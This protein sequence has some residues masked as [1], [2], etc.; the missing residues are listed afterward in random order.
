MMVAQFVIFKGKFT[1]LQL[2]KAIGLPTP[3]DFHPDF[4][5]TLDS[6]LVLIRWDFMHKIGTKSVMCDGKILQQFYINL[7]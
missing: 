4:D 6:I 7:Y 2:R 1:I 3:N 5:F